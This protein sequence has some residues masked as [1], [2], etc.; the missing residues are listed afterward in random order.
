MGSF[1]R[2]F[3]G[4]S[5]SREVCEGFG[6]FWFSMIDGLVDGFRMCL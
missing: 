3:S 1:G 2:V 6:W 5:G 4:D